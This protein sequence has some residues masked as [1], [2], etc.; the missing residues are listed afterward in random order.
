MSNDATSGNDSLINKL[1]LKKQFIN[2]LS[3]FKND[4]EHI[5]LQKVK[6]RG[7]PAFFESEKKKVDSIKCLIDDG[8]H[9]TALNELLDDFA[10]SDG[11]RYF[12][13][14]KHQEEGESGEKHNIEND[15]AT[16]STDVKVSLLVYRS[17]Y[18][19]SEKLM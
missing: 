2:F 8:S 12:N 19:I 13:K 15:T 10:K 16:K 6:E 4:N 18:Y 1:R 7:G 17:C 14:V 5:L 3:F 9:D 11:I